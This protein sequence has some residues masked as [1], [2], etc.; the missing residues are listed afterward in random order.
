MCSVL[1]VVL[2]FIM[3]RLEK[4]SAG[5]VSVSAREIDSAADVKRIEKGQAA[6]IEVVP[7]MAAVTLSSGPRR[8]LHQAGLVSMRDRDRD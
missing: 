4:E 3:H 5:E 7:T 8:A 1:I 6:A 2:M